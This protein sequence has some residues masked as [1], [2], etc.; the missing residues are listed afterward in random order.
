ML[1]LLY[2]IFVSRWA[3]GKED[4]Y[5]SHIGKD[6]IN[7]YE[8][9]TMTLLDK[10]SLKV[11]NVKDFNWSPTDPVLPFF[12]LEG[13]GGNQPAKVS[14]IFYYQNTKSHGFGFQF[15]FYDDKIRFEFKFTDAI[16]IRFS[17]ILM[18]IQIFI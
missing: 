13:G 2:I 17:I 9:Y 3:G 8:T 4:K 16:G 10:K 15:K 18:H 12:V 11:D 6:V 1:E 14:I 7:V 5:F